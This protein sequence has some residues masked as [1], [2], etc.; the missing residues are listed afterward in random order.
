MVP[1]TIVKNGKRVRFVQ[2]DHIDP[3][4][5]P[6]SGFT[7]WDEYIYR[8]YSNSDNYQLLCL[9]C[10]AGTKNKEEISQRATTNQVRKEF[11]DTYFTWAN[12][13]DRCSNPNATGYKYYGQKGIKVC[14]EW[15]RSRPD[16]QGI[17]NFIKDMGHRPKDHTLDRVDY[18]KDYTLENCRWA[19][20]KEQA[21]NTSANNWIDYNGELKVLQEWG[22]QLGIKP[23][24]ILTR[25][26]RGWTV[27]EA[28]EKEEK[29]KLVYDGRLTQDDL[30]FLKEGLEKGMT[31]TEI[32]EELEIHSSCISRI[33]RKLG[34]KTLT[35][36]ERE[37]LKSIDERAL[38]QS[39]KLSKKELPNG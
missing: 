3:V 7:T 10:H 39:T 14:D 9:D 19:T 37:Q 13:N 27:G 38:R 28:L 36:A 17:F 25:L 34:Y 4:V 22:E 23:N 32:A 12:M 8:M 16:M 21:R 2:V 26:R 35:K 18:N 24:S 11:P 29:P 31:Q 6:E 20:I 1:V 30:L 15:K 5:S 33:S